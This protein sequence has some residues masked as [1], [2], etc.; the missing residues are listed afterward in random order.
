M[1][2]T[3]QPIKDHY[4]QKLPS[5]IN[6]SIPSRKM[7]KVTK[8]M[9]W[10][11]KTKVKKSTKSREKLAKS[12][13]LMENSGTPEIKNEDQHQNEIHPTNGNESDIISLKLLRIAMKV[14]HLQLA[15]KAIKKLRDILTKRESLALKKKKIKQRSKCMKQK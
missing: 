12:T 1:T 13:I 9:K 6:K 8:K 10:K 2:K 14:K 7:G 11:S 5:N 15:D 4:Q 3:N